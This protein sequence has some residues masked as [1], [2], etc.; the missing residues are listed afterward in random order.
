MNE[1]FIVEFDELNEY[2]IVFDSVKNRVVAQY[3]TEEEANKLAAQKNGAQ[4]KS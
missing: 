4:K 1:R 2:F 3:P